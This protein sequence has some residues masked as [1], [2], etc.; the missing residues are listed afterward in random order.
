MFQVPLQVLRI[1]DKGIL[2]L[3]VLDQIKCLKR[4]N[5]VFNLDACPRR[6]I[7][8][9]PGAVKVDED[10]KQYERPIACE[11][12]VGVSKRASSVI[13]LEQWRYG[14]LR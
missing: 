7:L 10:A 1:D 13:A 14:H 6:Q 2:T 8:Q 4:R 9:C 12:T 5:H 3:P 11:I